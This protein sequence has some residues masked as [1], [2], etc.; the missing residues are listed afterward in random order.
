MASASSNDEVKVP[1]PGF[2]RYLIKTRRNI[3]KLN[4]MISTALAASLIVTGAY[5]E[6]AAKEGNET[7][8]TV[9]VKVPPIVGGSLVS[10]ATTTI[11]ATGYRASKLL[12]ADIYNENGEKIGKVD[13]LI[14]GG[15]GDVTFAVLSVGGFLGMGS[16]LVAVPAVLFDRNEKGQF[17][18]GHATK[19]ELKS[20]PA[21][22]YAK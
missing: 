2:A 19:E 5:A 17:I 6:M 8:K 11:Y 20:L 16:R 12:K 13:D 10:V 21:F 4:K 18:L 15:N 9:E 7:A 14:V 3:M 22:N 1:F